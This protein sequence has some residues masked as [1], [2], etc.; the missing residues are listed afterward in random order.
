MTKQKY[1][2]LRDEGDRWFERNKDKVVMY[3]IETDPVVAAI[4]KLD[5]KPKQVVEF[6]CGTGHRLAALRARYGCDIM[7]I[8]PSREALMEAAALRVPAIQSTA[9]SPP[10]STP[11][12]LIIY[13]FC[14]Y[15]TDPDDWL[16]IA[17]EANNVLSDG[18]H[19]IIHDFEPVETPYA[20]HY[21]HRN[22]IRAYHFDFAKLWLAHP[23]YERLS[24]E[25]V[26]DDQAVT[27]LRKNPLTI[28]VLS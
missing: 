14:L 10:L 20:R 3:D 4:R 13:G 22:G 9:S 21:S 5:L 27:V 2:F 11:F 1:V 16:Q 8:D 6:G 26:A 15:L 18:G 19:I 28:P 12:N 23:Q 25:R 17:A 7:G 24:S